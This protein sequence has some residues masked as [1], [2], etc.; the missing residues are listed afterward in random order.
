M[1]IYFD[2]LQTQISI[3]NRCSIDRKCEDVFANE[4]VVL[5]NSEEKKIVMH[6]NYFL[7]II[8]GDNLARTLSLSNKEQF[9]I[10]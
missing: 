4:K 9:R 3:I 7:T 8:C 10:L 2:E 6:E 1:V 5:F